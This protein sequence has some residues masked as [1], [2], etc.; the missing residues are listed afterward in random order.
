[1]HLLLHQ[2]LPLRPGSNMLNLAKVLIIG[3]IEAINRM[4]S[5]VHMNK[6]DF[7]DL[8]ADLIHTVLVIWEEKSVSK[9]AERLEIS[10]ST[11][12]HRLDRA[13]RVLDDPLFARKGRG[14][15]PTPF[16]NDRISTMREAIF[17]TQSLFDDGGIDPMKMEG[18]FTIA[19]TDYERILFLHDISQEIVREAPNLSVSYVWDKYDNQAALRRNQFDLAV[20]PY[21]SSDLNSDI[22]HQ[23]LFEDVLCSFYDPDFSD[24]IRDVDDYVSRKHVSVIFSDDDESFIDRALTSIGKSRQIVVRVPSIS[25]L[26]VLM[27]GSNIVAT[28]PSRLSESVMQ[29]FDSSPVPYKQPHITYGLFWH[30][31]TDSSPKHQWIRQKII[32]EVRQKFGYV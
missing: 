29:P 8:S 12:S 26:P 27:K 24:P 11:M 10:Q 14:L 13:R 15:V 16:L 6:F 7:R 1:M 9:A 25:E 32:D 4:G 21:L 18:R 2:I 3:N 19:A 20:A 28:L 22:C 17:A 31:T 5:I 23:R 30:K